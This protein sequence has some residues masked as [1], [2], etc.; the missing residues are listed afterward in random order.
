[1]FNLTKYTIIDSLRIFKVKIV[2]TILIGLKKIKPQS[3][4]ITQLNNSI[5]SLN[6]D[7]YVY[8]R[9]YYS[10]NEI[11]C[12]NKIAENIFQ[13]KSE[14]KLKL[15]RY[16]KYNQSIKIKNVQAAYTDLKLFSKDIFFILLSFFFN[17]KLTTNTFILNLTTSKEDQSE[18]KQIAG[19]PHIDYPQKSI[20]KC[21]IFLEDVSL[22]NG[23]TA[24]VKN[25]RINP[26][27][28][29]LYAHYRANP[30][31]ED[32]IDI[33]KFL[34]EDKYNKIVNSET[35]QYL[36]GKKGDVVFVDSSNIHWASNLIKGSRKIFWV[37]F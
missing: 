32:S 5:N 35:T 1:M 23:P 7:G 9:N 18:I 29:K 19:R 28:R 30:G 8:L 3:K 20:L 11:E 27:L 4:L 10:K 6:K 2:K 25:S 16:E 37:F 22:E 12:L 21:I 33:K 17:L 14:D 36:T 24:I 15:V 26:E 34:G 31:K 13:E